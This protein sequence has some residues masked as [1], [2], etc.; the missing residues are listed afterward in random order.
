MI[1]GSYKYHVV[2]T[3]TSWNTCITLIVAFT[4]LYLGWDGGGD[5][6]GFYMKLLW[7]KKWYG[8]RGSEGEENKHSY[9]ILKNI[10]RE[11]THTV[12]LISD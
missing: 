3:I 2:V 1:K 5:C 8:R 7:E 12:N 4:F 11:G 10:E 9:R 6:Q